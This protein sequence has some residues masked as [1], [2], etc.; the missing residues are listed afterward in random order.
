MLLESP[1]DPNPCSNGGTCSLTYDELD[2]Y[3]ARVIFNLRKKTFFLYKSFI[4]DTL[5]TKDILYQS[6]PVD[7]DS[8][9]T[10]VMT[11]Y[12]R[13][14]PVIIEETVLFLMTEKSSVFV[15]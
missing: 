14:I 11:V 12:V 4:F 3:Q 13:V 5:R 6:V 2:P 8:V 7:L 9:V 10:I 15:L 1:C